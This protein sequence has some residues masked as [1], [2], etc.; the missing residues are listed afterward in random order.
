MHVRLPAEEL[1]L[2]GSVTHVY[3]SHGLKRITFSVHG[4]LTSVGEC[5]Y[6]VVGITVCT[7]V[8]IYFV[9]TTTPI[10]YLPALRP[11]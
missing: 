11:L 2:F 5:D 1:G 7:M 10:L 6:H 4:D 3:R 9:V 8:L